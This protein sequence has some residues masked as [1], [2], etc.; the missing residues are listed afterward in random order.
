MKG[1]DD[2]FEKVRDDAKTIDNIRFVGAVPYSEVNSYFSRAKLFLNTS[3][4]EG[5]PNSFLQAWVRG[6]PVVSFFDPDGLIA[7]EGLGISVNTQDD[8]KEA[9]SG[10]LGQDDERLRIGQRARQFVIDRYGSETIVRE[11]ERLIQERFGIGLGD[12]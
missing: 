5:F 10:L 2:L 4:S 6:V 12:A 8:F 7:S 9:L 11:Y 3:D 1:Y